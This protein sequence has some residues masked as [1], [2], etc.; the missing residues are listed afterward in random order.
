MP[1]INP[2]L[3]ATLRRHWPLIGAI[4]IF[5]VFTV[6]DQLMFGPAVRRYQRAVK[7]ASDLG[8]PIDVR[9]TPAVLPPR[10]FALLSDNAL[11]EA[12]AQQR[13]NSG[14]LAAQLL[15]D[16]TDTMSRRQIQVIATEPGTV[17]QQKGSVQVRAHMRLR[18]RYV[19]FVSLLEDLSRN[20]KL[21]AIDRFQMT[22]DESGSQLLEI[23][24]SRYVLKQTGGHR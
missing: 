21:Y 12:E 3:G 13:G 7:Q 5:L 8:M 18:C 2:I 4:V 24:V 16:L 15:E 1:L 10:L 22:A 20:N 11:P 17:S 23:W 19:Q 6:T 9:S 14:E